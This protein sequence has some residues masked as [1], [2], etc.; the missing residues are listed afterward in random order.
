VSRKRADLHGRVEQTEI[1]KCVPR[2]LP[3]RSGIFRARAPTRAAT[4]TNAYADAETR[5][6]QYQARRRALNVDRRLSRLVQRF[7]SCFLHCSGARASTRRATCDSSRA[8]LRRRASRSE[9]KYREWA[10]AKLTPEFTAAEE[11]SRV[12]LIAG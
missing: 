5:A 2:Y 6:R 11:A 4:L 8:R 9:R 1:S 12:K 7:A 10:D 3:N